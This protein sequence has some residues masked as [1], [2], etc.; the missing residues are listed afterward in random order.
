MR[1]EKKYDM[2]HSPSA[3][4]SFTS[5]VLQANLLSLPACFRRTLFH[6]PRASGEPSFTSR[7]KGTN[8]IS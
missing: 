4:P 6:V 8:V 2:G 3:R 5:R 7:P 1:I